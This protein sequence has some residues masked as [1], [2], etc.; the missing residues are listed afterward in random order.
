MHIHV[1]YSEKSFFKE[2]NLFKKFTLI[3]QNNFDLFYK[4]VIYKMGILN[5][6][7]CNFGV[8]VLTHFLQIDKK[9]CEEETLFSETIDVAVPVTS[10][11]C[12]R[13]GLSCLK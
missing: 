5:L 12:N 1:L 6:N 2:R 3:I 11:Y 13:V 7:L 8:I 10:P 9:L 4:T